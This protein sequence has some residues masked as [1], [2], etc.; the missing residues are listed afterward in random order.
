MYTV[1]IKLVKDEFLELLRSTNREGIE[2]VITDLEELGFFIAPASAG[3]H[4]NVPGGLVQHSLNT[5][6]AAL[7]VWEGM[8][9][10][11]PS[12]A[13]EVDRENV[14]IASL[15]HDVCKS[16]IYKPTVKRKKNAIGVWEDVEGY[17]VS[18]KKFPMGHGEKSVIQL[19]CSGLAMTDDEMLAI[20]WHMGPWGLNFNSYEDQ[21]SY[22]TAQELYPLVA[23]LHAADSLAAAIME[24]EEEDLEE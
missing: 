1:N 8:K 4:L 19:L 24:R 9:N 6:K 2:D 5:C 16:D 10:V 17:N 11:Q 21:R 12:L 3:H 15:L 22:D 23:I 18:Y 7:A 20:R 13:N 14:I